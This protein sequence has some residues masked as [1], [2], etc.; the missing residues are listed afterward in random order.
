MLSNGTFSKM[1]WKQKQFLADMPI[2]T[3]TN[4]VIIHN[5][6]LPWNCHHDSFG[7][8]FTLSLSI[9]TRIWLLLITL[10]TIYIVRGDLT[11]NK[12]RLKLNGM[13]RKFITPFSKGSSR[14]PWWCMH[15]MRE[16]LKRNEKGLHQ[17]HSPWQLQHD[18]RG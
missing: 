3:W 10:W 2:H 5:L 18:M 12:T 7:K 11:F 8:R 13:R 17:Q 4:N 16:G 9:Y 14:N 6:K 15:C 1:M